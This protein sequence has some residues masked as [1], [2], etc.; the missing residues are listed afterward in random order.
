MLGKRITST[1]SDVDFFAIEVP[2]GDAPVSLD[3]SALPNL[4]SCVQIFRKGMAAPS[5]Q[6]CPGLPS[7]DLQIPAL[8]LEPGAYYITVMQDLDA[9]GKAAPFVHENVSDEYTVTLGPSS[10][11]ASFEIEPNDAPSSAHPIGADQTVSGMLGWVGDVDTYCPKLDSTAL[12]RFRVDDDPREGGAV[13]SVALSQNGAEGRAVRVHARRS[14]PATDTDAASPFTGF[15]FRGTSPPCLVV[16]LALDPGAA[17]STEI[18][19]R[20]S[21]AKY[22]VGLEVVP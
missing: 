13:L 2:A 5:A 8:R 6:Y 1:Q 20:G 15:S 17:T 11:E 22:R 4:A 9:R 14:K 10:G 3:V 18:V 19:P 12:Y 16:R 21:H 7:L